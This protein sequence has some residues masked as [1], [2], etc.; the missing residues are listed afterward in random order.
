M[1]ALLLP[2]M[3]LTLGLSTLSCQSLDNLWSWRLSAREP[4]FQSTDGHYFPPFIHR[5]FPN[6]R[7]FEQEHP[8]IDQARLGLHLIEVRPVNVDQVNHNESNLSW[9][10]NGAYLSYETLDHRNRHI[11]L[12]ALGGDFEKRLAMVPRGQQDFLQGLVSQ[13]VLSYNSGLSWAS[14]GKRYAFMSNGGVGTYNIY[15]G[16]I[17]ATEQVVAHSSQKE[18]YAVW[19]PAGSELAFVSA[20]T[21]QGDLYLLE[22]SSNRLQRLTFSD[23]P[24]LFPEWLPDGSGLVYVSGSSSQHQI[25]LIKRGPD[26]TWFEPK[27]L[28]NWQSDSL[29][30]RVSPC[31]RWLAFY[32]SR[33]QENPYQLGE[34]NT[35]DLHLIPLKFVNPSSISVL[36]DRERL[37]SVIARD[38][39]VDLN[40]GPAW[41]PDG[42]KVFYVKQDPKLFNPIY[43]F[44]LHRHKTLPV[45]TGTRMNRDI[46]MSSLGVLSFRA[47]VGAWDRIFVALTNQ[48][49]QL[50]AATP[51]A[52]PEK[53]LSI[54]SI[55]TSKYW[56]KN[57]P[58]HKKDHSPQRTT[59]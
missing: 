56:Q 16:A 8:H 49:Q 3:I 23:N 28:T 53:A 48:G 22:I 15:I 47:Q 33:H 59:L 44:D 4:L 31:G 34:Q 25:M 9:S 27:A 52:P 46:L 37:Q 2:S 14:D 18:G 55:F 19:N 26:Q 13:K 5:F 40:T 38:V 1:K 42:G 57:R 30:P 51:A 7:R 32:A 10:A 54:K 21:G 29:R 12:R 45:H 17:N 36:S 39:M 50:Q 20:R 35:W 41:S 58:N 24:D 6:A 11:M 43:V